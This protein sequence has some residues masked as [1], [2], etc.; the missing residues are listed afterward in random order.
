MDVIAILLMVTPFILFL[1]FIHFCN[2]VI[3]KEGE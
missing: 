3:A 2:K 1:G